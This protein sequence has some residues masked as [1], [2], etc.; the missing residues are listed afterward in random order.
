MK[1]TLLAL[2]TISS[3]LLVLSIFQIVSHKNQ[4]TFTQ[5]RENSSQLFG[6]WRNQ[7]SK[8]YSSPEELKYRFE[9]FY[10]NLVLVRSRNLE[11][12][13]HQLALNLFADLTLEEFKSKFTGYKKKS[14]NLNSKIADLSKVVAPESWDWREKGAITEVKNQGA[15]G[16]CWAFS[17]TGTVEGAY[18]IQNQEQKLFSEQYLVDCDNNGDFGCNGGEMT[19]AL[20]YISQFGIPEEK[21]YPYK[22]RDQ[23]CRK[24][25]KGEFFKISGWKSVNQNA[26]DW[27]KAS[28]TA[29]LAIGIEADEIRF[30]KSGVFDDHRCGKEL[31]HGVLLVGYGVAED[32][33]QT[34]YWIVKN[35]WGLTW[36]DEGYIKFKKRYEEKGQCLWN[37]FGS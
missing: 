29:P 35:S 4:P 7:Y 17:T 32:R 9:V 13:T 30:Y 1:A 33:H 25:I 14:T 23:K 12:K 21:N 10:K 11:S 20:T 6:A 36:G 19:N 15:C 16:S 3:I 27:M 26:K 34:P 28:F 18:F 2:T 8:I 24:D 37:S 5:D 31:D 22:A